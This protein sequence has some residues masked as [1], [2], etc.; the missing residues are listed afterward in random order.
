MT[1]QIPARKYCFWDNGAINLRAFRGNGKEPDFC[2]RL[3]NKRMY[4]FRRIYDNTLQQLKLVQGDLPDTGEFSKETAKFFDY[5]EQYLALGLR[6]DILR[7]HL[8]AMADG[9]HCSIVDFVFKQKIN[10]GLKLR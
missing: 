6:A 7:I 3:C 10:E 4:N 9:K 5:A 2:D 1:F 8:D